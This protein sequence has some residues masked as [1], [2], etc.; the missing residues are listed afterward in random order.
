MIRGTFGPLDRVVALKQRY[1]PTN[2]L[3]G[4]RLVRRELDTTDISAHCNVGG[5]EFTT[6]GRAASCAAVLKGVIKVDARRKPAE[7]CLSWQRQWCG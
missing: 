2:L 6:Y 4:R 1:D 5:V 3:S 7:R